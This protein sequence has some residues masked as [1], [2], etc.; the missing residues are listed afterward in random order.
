MSWNRMPA[1][2]LVLAGLAAVAMTSAFAADSITI[3]TLS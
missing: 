3:T 2:S 1:G